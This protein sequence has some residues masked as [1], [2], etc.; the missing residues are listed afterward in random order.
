MPRSVVPIADPPRASSARPVERDVGW[1]E[2]R[3]GGGNPQLLQNR[4]ALS[5]QEVDFLEQGIQRQHHAVPDQAFDAR[6]EN[7]GRNQ[8]QNRLLA[9]NHQGVPGV[10][11][12]LE[13]DYGVG[14]GRQE[15]D[16]LALPFVAPLCADDDDAS[17]HDVTGRATQ[18]PS[19][20]TSCSEHWNSSAESLRP[21]PANHN[22]ALCAQFSDCILQGRVFIRTLHKF[23][24]ARPHPESRNGPTC[25]NPN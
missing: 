20:F 22:V 6:V 11:P 1:Q 12:P 10:M 14:V 5:Q 13:P 9:L 21:E 3:T 24:V 4:E 25:A 23:G 8:V 18:A 19:S 2:Q 7:A 17:I 15:V 16:D